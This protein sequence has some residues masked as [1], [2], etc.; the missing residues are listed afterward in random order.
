MEIAD[1]DMERN[2]QQKGKLQTKHE[3]CQ[4]ITNNIKCEKLVAMVAQTR[5]ISELV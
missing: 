4:D 2:D 1:E 3:E 5:Q